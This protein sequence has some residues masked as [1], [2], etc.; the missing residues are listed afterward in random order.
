V[1]RLPVLL[2]LLLP[3]WAAG[4]AG[5]AID[6]DTLAMVQAFLKLPTDQLPAEHVP[7]FLDVDPEALPAKLKKPFL[8]RRLEL[9][10][11]KH[12]AEGRKKG[13]IR[14]PEENC[15]APKEASS[16]DIHI[17]KIAGYAEITE[18]EEKFLMKETKCTEH[19]LM[20][21]FSL[22]VIL[23][24]ENKIDKRRLFLHV[25]DPMSALVGMY[26]QYGRTRQTNFFGAGFPTCAP[27]L[28]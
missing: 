9:Y 27:R 24:K 4:P 5:K 20:C 26:R 19:D 11:L 18:D 25:K 21:E 22:Q 16:R 28:K 13:S 10:T 3:A 8:A 7:R 23:D 14:M 6:A 1:V 17:L 12:L 15:I 2:F